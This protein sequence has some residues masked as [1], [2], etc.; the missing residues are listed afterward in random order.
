MFNDDI[1]FCPD[2]RCAYTQC[3]R[4]PKN[5][6]FKHLPHSYFVEIPSDCPFKKKLSNK[7]RCKDEV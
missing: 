1:T 5:I 4:N 6:V 3:M 7:E 2:D